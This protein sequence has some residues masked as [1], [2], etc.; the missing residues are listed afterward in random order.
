[1]FAMMAPYPRWHGTSHAVP[2][3]P[4]IPG[5]QSKY[6]GKDKHPQVDFYSKKYGIILKFILFHYTYFK[7]TFFLYKNSLQALFKD[8]KFLQS[9]RAPGVRSISFAL[10]GA[11]IAPP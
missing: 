5:K 9:S 7:I 10:D 8:Q 2:R 1:M 4:L 3:F 11:I 6:R